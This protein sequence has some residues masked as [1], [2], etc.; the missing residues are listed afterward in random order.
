MPTKQDLEHMD[1]IFLALMCKKLSQDK[2]VE[3]KSAEKAK[4]MLD[5]WITVTEG[6]ALPAVGTKEYERLQPKIANL[7]ARM[8]EFLFPFVEFSFVPTEQ[9]ERP[10]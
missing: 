1:A 4:K 9:R 7:K 2:T 5:E 10:Q 6:K 3:T 8:V